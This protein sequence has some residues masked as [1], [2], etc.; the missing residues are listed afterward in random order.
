M[1]TSANSE[2]LVAEW[3]SR[4][5]LDRTEP[6]LTVHKLGMEASIPQGE[7]KTARWVRYD[8]LAANLTPLTEKTT[9]AETAITN[10]ETQVIVSQYGGWACVSDVLADTSRFNNLQQARDILSDSAKKTIEQLN[11][12]E[13]DSEGYELFVNDRATEDD[14]V[15]TDTAELE[16]FICAMQLQRIDDLDPHSN[17]EHAAVLNKAVVFDVLVDTTG[18]SFYDTMKH[19]TRGQD[20]IIKGDLGSLYGLRFMES[21]LMTSED[22]AGGIAVKNSYVFANQPFGT[23]DIKNQGI[24]ILMTKAGATD[25]DPLDQR[26]KVGYKF[27]YASKYLESGSKRAVVIRSAASKG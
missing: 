25:S 17:G 16:D 19:T 7:S 11:I 20:Q 15:A 1:D 6:E 22:N 10:T 21:G 27:Y 9:P 23:V 8:S 2:L 18:V 24:K 3:L 4:K 14:I 12:N 26:R 5:V 13:I